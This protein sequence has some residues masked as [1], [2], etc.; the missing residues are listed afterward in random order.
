MM[1]R[2]WSAMIAAAGV[3]SW[4]LIF[5]MQALSV[6]A[7]ALCLVVWKGP[8]AADR[9]PQQLDILGWSLWGILLILALGF[10]SLASLGVVASITKSGVNLTVGD[11]DAPTSATITTTTETKVEPST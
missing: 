1:G 7:A 2:I 10:I 3:R 6:F 4:A 8:W 9:Q 5:G 11:E